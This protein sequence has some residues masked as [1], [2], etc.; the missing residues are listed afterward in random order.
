[1]AEADLGLQW[2]Q[3]I[4]SLSHV[5]LPFDTLDP[6]YGMYPAAGGTD[7]HLGKIALRGERGVLKLSPA[8]MLRQRSNPFFSYLETRVLAFLGLPRDATSEAG[9]G[10][11]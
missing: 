10:T 8:D 1:M 7:L 5:A 3:G 9:T 2:A 4:Y 6:L 11:Q